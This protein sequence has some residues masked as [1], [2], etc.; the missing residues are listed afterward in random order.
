MLNTL[1]PIGSALRIPE[2]LDEDQS[3]FRADK[4]KHLADAIDYYKTHGYVV[5]RGLISRE[6]CVKV[7]S[8]FDASVRGTK[9]PMLRQKN[10]R[11]ER[12][13]FDANGFVDN[14][15]FNLQDIGSGQ[16]A[17]FR[18]AVLDVLTHKV[19]ALATAALLGCDKSMMIQSMFFEAPAGTWAHQ[20][21]YYQDSASGLGQCVAGW[22]ALE[23][24]DAGSGRLYIC[25]GS[26][27][28]V[29]VLR[30][31]RE[32][33]FATGHA[34]YQRAVLA[35]IRLYGLSFTAPY[36]A[37]GD[38]LFWNSLTIHGSLPASRVGVSRASLTAHYLRDGDAMLQFHSRIRGQ[39]TMTYNGMRIGLLHDQ[40]RL[41]NRIVRTVAFRMPR[42]YM[43]AR[44]LAL[45]GL[46]AKQSLQ[47]VI[48]GL[49]GAE[50]VQQ[51]PS[52]TPKGSV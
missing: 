42:P 48:A 44:T 45:R 18:N 30:N 15:I 23:D 24:I 9:L 11:Y 32:Y 31:E 35:M 21:S 20:D 8:V 4:P 39:A 29:P 49:R 5:M 43:T 46:L 10:M 14:P 47:R 1:T 27:R 41:F 34:A 13:T 12:N 17:T 16:L 25:P 26:H 28:V 3:Y 38:V 50:M 33:N 37:A 36:L 7:R 22:F 51:P 19:G 6:L 2:T 40:D 52:V